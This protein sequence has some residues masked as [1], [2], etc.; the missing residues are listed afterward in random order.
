MR[1]EVSRVLGLPYEMPF[2]PALLSIV[3]KF[4]SLLL[5]TVKSSLSSMLRDCCVHLAFLS[6][7]HAISREVLTIPVPSAEEFQ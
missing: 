2:Y 4:L 7:V 6:F 1:V 3:H 5:S